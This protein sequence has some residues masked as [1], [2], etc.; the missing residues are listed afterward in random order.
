MEELEIMSNEAAI[1]IHLVM[2]GEK[3][4]L[5]QDWAENLVDMCEAHKVALV[6]GEAPIFKWNGSV[7]QPGAVSEIIMMTADDIACEIEVCGDGIWQI[8]RL[9]YKEDL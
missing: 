9:D 4:E 7:H 5:L 1:S 3:W 8:T 2:K 6:K